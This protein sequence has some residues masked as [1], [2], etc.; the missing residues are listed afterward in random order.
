MKKV[1]ILASILL[2]TG[3]VFNAKAQDL[4]EANKWSVGLNLGGHDAVSPTT[5]SVKFF[6][7]V[8]GDVRYMFNNRFGLM[9]DLGYENFAWTSDT[10]TNN[11]QLTRLSLQ[12]VVNV[13]DLLR[14][15]SFYDRIGLLVHGGAG[16]SNMWQKDA[17]SFGEGDLMG[18]FIAGITPQFK[19]TDRVSVNL[20]WSGVFNSN[21]DR[22][23]D[24][25][26]TNKPDVNGINAFYMTASAGVKIAL[27]KGE[28]HV[29]WIPT[30]YGEGNNDDLL[31]R[32]NDLEEK[33]KD[34]DKD[35][36]PDWKDAEPNSAAGVLVNSN[37]V[38]VKVP[39]D[40]DNDG[41][42]DE[43][44]ACPNVKG[45]FSGNGCPDSDKDGVIDS[46]DRCPNV[47][48]SAENAGCPKVDE[49]T[50]EAL[51]E[52]L[53]GIKFETGKATIKSSSF[54]TLG[55]VVS[56]LDNHKNYDLEIHGHT[57]NVGNPA[58]N[59]KLSEERANS[60]KEYLVSKGIDA[61]RLTAFGHGDTQPVESNDT[62]EGRA[63]NRRV[64]FIVI[65]NK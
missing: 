30:V 55:K 32:I 18:N 7:H 3:A 38:E 56:A 65:F 45:T 46:E 6:T 31:K 37:G 59:L 43:Y 54:S 4:S 12:G 57:D 16:I 62:P 48:G 21:Q 28:K 1:T 20:D 2:M 19:V 13:G 10:A 34:S 5:T 23:F 35:G 22:N 36:V 44:D 58:S 41:I 26:S 49:K 25:K 60:V 11:T 9:G 14:F 52:A 63:D 64:E 8:N 47:P 51:D 15:D 33:V 50:Q 53:H 27:G 40:A 24:F 17:F 42:I 39:A 61:S 29:D